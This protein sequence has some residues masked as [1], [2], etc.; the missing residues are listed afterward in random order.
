MVNV[1]GQEYKIVEL[2]FENKT[3]DGLCDFTTKEIKL[4]SDLDKVTEESYQNMNHY[5]QQV[6]RHEIIH[7]FM[8][9][10]WLN[11]N[12]TFARDET[13]IDW[14]AIQLPKMVK[15]MKEVGCID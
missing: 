8:F 4:D 12:S 11:S 9:E 5:K 7:A 10:S 14:I 13:L 15:A 2:N 6:V 3:Y 1:L